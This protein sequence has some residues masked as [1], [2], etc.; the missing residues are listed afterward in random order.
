LSWDFSPDENFKKQLDWIKRFVDEE[1]LPLE[2]IRTYFSDEA[3]E[4]VLQP[5]KQKVKDQGLWAAHLPKE[6][7]TQNKG[8]KRLRE[9]VI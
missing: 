2:P 4:S 8:W 9:W 5:L 6:L 7:G 1:L 3:W